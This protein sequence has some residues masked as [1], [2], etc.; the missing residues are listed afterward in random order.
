MKYKTAQTK[1]RKKK[2]QMHLLKAN[3]NILTDFDIWSEV[4]ESGISKHKEH[5]VSEWI[6]SIK[7]I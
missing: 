5:K 7:M 6:D 4:I 2:T 3:K 1:K